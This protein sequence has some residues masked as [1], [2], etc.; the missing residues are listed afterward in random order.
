MDKDSMS[1]VVYLIH[2]CSAKWNNSPEEVYKLLKDAN[3]INDYLVPHYDVLHTQGTSY[4]VSDI[5]GYLKLRGI[6]V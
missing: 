2:A 3:C 1:F 4:L 5:E 6:T